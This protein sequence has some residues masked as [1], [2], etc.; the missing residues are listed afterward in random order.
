MIGRVALALALA[1]PPGKSA[2]PEEIPPGGYYELGE[3]REREPNDGETNTLVGSILFPLGLLRA[4]AAVA[5]LVTAAPGTCQERYGT[6]ISDR[7]CQ[8]LRTYGWVGIG[9]GGLMA[10]T[11]AAF[12]GIGLVQRSRHRT[13]KI[14]NGVTLAPLLRPSGGGLSL[15]IR[16]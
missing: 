15:S 12:L 2:S 14:R 8:S 4:G 5:I 16:F 6:G 11:G 10:V 1:S 13:W 9:Y 3:V 7:S